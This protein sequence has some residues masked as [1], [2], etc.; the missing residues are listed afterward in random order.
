MNLAEAGLALTLFAHQIPEVS[1]LV[2]AQECLAQKL[3][4]HEQDEA[5]VALSRSFLIF[6]SMGGASG[7]PWAVACFQQPDFLKLLTT[8][9]GC[10]SQ[11]ERKRTHASMLRRLARKLLR[12]P[13]R[14]DAALSG[15]HALLA[16][17]TPVGARRAATALVYVF[18]SAVIEV[19]GPGRA[20]LPEILVLDL[21]DAFQVCKVPLVVRGSKVACASGFNS[22]NAAT[23]F[24]VWAM[25]T[26]RWEE[27][28][29]I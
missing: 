20:A 15:T 19:L 23:Q 12:M 3:K 7:I 17:A 29:S 25:G 22:Q 26:G 18:D 21:L 6:R 13:G 4:S 14:S 16:L 11:L 5:V 28:V 1:R 27:P 10:F 24:L 8:V 2:W 9:P